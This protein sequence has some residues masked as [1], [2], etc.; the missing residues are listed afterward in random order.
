MHK[1]LLQYLLLTLAMASASLAQAQEQPLKREFRAVWIATVANIDWPGQKGLSPAV[2]QQEFKY[3]LDEH[4]KNGMNAVIVQVRP[5]ADALYRSNLEPWSEFLTG[6][7]G[8][9]M[10]PP[11]DPL[12]FMLEEAHKRGME[13]HAWFNPY[14]ATFDAKAEVAPN[15]ITKRRPEWFI[16][17]EGK[18]LFNP[19]IPEV[20][21]YITSVVMDVVNRYDI[22]GVHFDDYFYPYPVP[23][24]PF[25]DEQTYAAYQGLF[26]NKDDWR[27]YNVDELIKGVSDSI[28]HVKPWV[29]FGISPFGVWKNLADGPDGSATRAG[30]PSYTAL[31]A[32]TRKWMQVGWIDYLVPQVYWHIGNPAADYK[33]VLEWWAQNAFQRHLYVGLGAYKVASD[34]TYR[35]W[36]D[37]NEMPRQLQLARA[38]PNVGGS[39][40]FSSKSVMSNPNNL[41]DSL[42]N[43]YYKYPALLPVM[44]WKKNAELEPPFSLKVRQTD[45]GVRLHWQHDQ[46]VRYYVIYR[47][48]KESFWETPFWKRAF[49]EERK[50]QPLDPDLSSPVSIVAKVFGTN[51]AFIDETPLESGKYIYVVTALDRQ[52]NESAPSHPATVKY[53][54]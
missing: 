15:H 41:Q 6:K 42:R 13:F 9:A 40:F 28:N 8:Q 11:Y 31:Y 20:R 50:W 17:Y 30:A 47:F 29:K 4:Q 51:T 7:Q 21:Q 38:T 3:I 12:Q 53:K 43:S 24:K 54:Y 48:V 26:T 18:L 46:E 35:E 37:P 34:P 2:Q 19:G 36:H 52:Q 32:D 44:D 45:S 25:P 23:K 10:N 1:S 39:V 27:R 49:W 33:T 16:K 14:R 5:A 22:D